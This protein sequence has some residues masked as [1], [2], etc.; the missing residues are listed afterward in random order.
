MRKNIA[1]VI[2]RTAA[3]L[4]MDRQGLARITRLCAVGSSEDPGFLLRVIAPEKSHS[5]PIERNTAR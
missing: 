2:D 4:L 1:V 5:Y 3:R